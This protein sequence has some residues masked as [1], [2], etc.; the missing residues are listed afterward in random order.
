METTAMDGVR[1]THSAVRKKIR[2]LKTLSAAGPD[3]I[4]PKLLQEL[5]NE[6]TPVLVKI[7]NRSVQYGEI[8][9]DWRKANVTPLF[10]KGS[11]ADPGNYRPVSLTSV[12][13]K[14]LESVIRDAMM[15]HLL[16]NNLL[17]RSQHGFMPGKSCTT[18]LLEFMDKVTKV[19]DTG[20]PFDVI[21]LDFAQAFDKVSRERLLEKLH[22]HGERGKAWHWIR[23]WLTGR[24]HRVVLNWKCSTWAEVLSG[25]PQDS[26]LGPPIIFLTF[27]NDLDSC[28]EFIEI[29]RKFADDSKLGHTAATAEERESLQLA[30]DNLCAW[31]E[32]WGMEFNVKKCK[33]M[34]LGHNNPAQ[35]Y[36]MN[37]Q[38]LGVTEEERD[39]G[40]SMA[41]NLK[42]SAQC[43]KAA[44]TAQTVL[45][46]LA[47]AFHYRDRH[48][49]LKLYVQY[50]RPHLEFA[51]AAWSP[52]LEADKAVLEKVQRRAITMI[53]GLRNGTYEEK[54][55]ELGITTL[56]ERRH[57]SDM[58]Q[59]FKILHGYDKV[60]TEALFKS[61]C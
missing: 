39:I 3:E 44:R 11:K 10:K 58:L 4:G 6:L 15:N 31:A 12:C 60:E 19:I 61:R 46:Q 20:K 8:P 26:V 1:I 41:K 14:V 36:T 27:I 53:S 17:N 43:A 16:V 48:I 22:A 38:Q 40:V 55:L 52:W 9:E 51:V 28:V 21:F 32:R 29:L 37:N 54:L 5:E 56:E 25:V 18:N 49:F 42:P 47:R 7:F 30:L 33:V 50:V 24:K 23:N 59:T 45:A 13:C 2:K 34:H 57:Q 35:A